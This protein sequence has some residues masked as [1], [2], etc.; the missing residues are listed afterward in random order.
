M[1]AYF[2]GK[3]VLI[4]GLGR[5]G[6][7]ADAAR[8]ACEAG[9]DV[10]ITDT[11]P[12][13][14]LQVSLKQLKAF[15]QIQYRL[16]RHEFVD[17]DKADVIIV[18]PA[19]EPENQFLRYAR[20][21]GKKVS[22]QISIFFELCPARI[23]GITGASGKST[24][25]S[26]TAHLLRAGLAWEDCWY[27][28]VWLSGNIG[29]EPLLCVLDEIGEEDL[30]VLELSSFQIEQLALKA[31]APE[32][33]LLTNLFANHLDRY[34]T[35]EAYCDAKE[36]MFRL[37]KMK[38]ARPAV[39]I[40]NGNDRLGRE[41]YDQYSKE[42]G[43]ICLTYSA[44]DV[45]GD[46]REVFRL[47]GRS[48]L[49]N[50][51]GAIAVAKY[52]DVKEQVIKESLPEFRGLAHRL[53]LVAE[54]NGIRWYNDSKAT[55][56][57]AAM[58]AIEAF[59]EPEIIIAGG[60]DKQLSFDELGERIAERAKA[61]IL[62]GATARKIAEAI[63]CR[64]PNRAIIRYAGDLREAVELAIELAE[65]GDVVLLS[66]ACASYDMFDNYQ[67]RGREFVRFIDEVTPQSKSGSPVGSGDD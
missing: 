4:M 12:A 54:M 53:E 62:I 13:K 29:N 20:E 22:S 31:Q 34:G 5:F 60:Y 14:E 58:A 11:A 9:G 44:D 48:N 55:T 66:P 65:N 21:K 56:P 37:Q 10:T 15:P 39:S 30:V 45:T 16:G 26:L 46:I 41:W 36:Q 59:E 7:G 61:A 51:A 33:G 43:R 8:F 50:L 47:P 49:S 67:Q 25:A 6:G 24:T 19:I 35:F 1:R 38:Y 27:R 40:F 28:Q 52:F 63:E 3:K 32:V 42:E 57:E 23:I 17:F 64:S 18:N 2:C